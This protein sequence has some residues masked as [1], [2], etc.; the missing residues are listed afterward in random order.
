MSWTDK[1][2][3]T[4]ERPVRLDVAERFAPDYPT[5][6]GGWSCL[7]RSKDEML[8]MLDECRRMYYEVGE[9]WFSHSWNK[10]VNDGMD[11][12]SLDV[13]ECAPEEE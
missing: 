3:A 9:P 2:V 7:I 6:E 12:W 1:F 11:H 5:V 10:R 13:Y 4:S 8:Q